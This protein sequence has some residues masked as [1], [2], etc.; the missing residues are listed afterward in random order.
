MKIIRTK[1]YAEMSQ[2]ACEHVMDAVKNKADIN[3]GSATGSTPEGMYECLIENNKQGKVSFK[4]VTTFNLD[5]YI[6]LEPEHPNSYHYFMEENF[7]KH[8]DIQAENTHL[9]NGI[10]DDFEKECLRYEKLI[11]SRSEEHTS[12]LQSRGH[13][14]CRLLLENKNYHK[15]NIM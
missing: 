6:G 11:E 7:F 12:E 4:K 15:I 1:D 3:L 9:P 14:L 8:I 10:A 13:L 5:E 2:L